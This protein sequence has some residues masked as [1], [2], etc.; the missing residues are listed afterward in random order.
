MSEISDYIKLAAL[1]FNMATKQ[2][3]ETEDALQSCKK[4]L[5]DCTEWLEKQSQ[6]SAISFPKNENHTL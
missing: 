5:K 4:R 2:F 6:T 3:K 1:N